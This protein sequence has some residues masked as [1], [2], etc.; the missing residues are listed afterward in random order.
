MMSTH[1][2]LV[3]VNINLDRQ[4]LDG[5]EAIRRRFVDL[6]PSLEVS[7]LDWRDVSKDK[8]TRQQPAAVV[9]GPNETPFP[10]Y[11]PDFR[12]F[13]AWV[14]ARQGA[15]LGICGG[16]QVLGLA[17][18]AEVGPVFDVPPA[19]H[20]YKGMPKVKGEVLVHLT[21]AEDPLLVGLPKEMRVE[22][23]HVDEVKGLPQGFV[24]LA[25]NETSPTQIMRAERRPI[26]GI[27]FH[28]E[29]KA[30]GDVGKILLRNWLLTIEI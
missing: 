10:A 9:L 14:K 6:A 1:P 15:T 17:H 8:I 20:S 21:G 11:P 19:T 30:S 28:P 13:L 3:V 23:S 2:R 7:V 25:H 16:H 4:T 29:R 24:L 26:Y 18:G 12:R 27:Q 5:C 22:A